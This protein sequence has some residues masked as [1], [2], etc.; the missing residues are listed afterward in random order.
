VVKVLVKNWQP[1]IASVEDMIEIATQRGS[2]RP[3]HDIDNNQRAESCQVKK[4]PDTFLRPTVV[5]CT[6]STSAV[7]RAD[8]P[9]NTL[10]IIK[11]R[12]RV[13]ASRQRRKLLDK[14]SL[15]LTR[16]FRTILFMGIPFV[17]KIVS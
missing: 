6:F 9:F 11:K 5:W 8:R 10:K 15:T 16:T 12:N 17:L 13:P 1:S 4:G 14:R 7:C 3:A 2:P